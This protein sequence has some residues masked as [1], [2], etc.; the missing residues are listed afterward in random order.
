MDCRARRT[1]VP[2]LCED[3]AEEEKYQEGGRAD[4]SIGCKRGRFVE[5]GLVLL[6]QR[7][8]S[9]ESFI[10]AVLINGTVD[11]M[12]RGE[13]TL[14]KRDVCAETAEKGVDSGS[15]AS[16]VAYRGAKGA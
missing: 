1:D 8:V 2:A 12:N 5:V 14:V 11:E 16:M 10:D 15:G 3:Y 4:P 7:S 6:G 13:H 9:T